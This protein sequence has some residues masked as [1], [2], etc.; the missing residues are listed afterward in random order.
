MKKKQLRNYFVSQLNSS[1][2][3]FCVKRDVFVLSK[4]SYLSMFIKY[5]QNYPHI[6]LHLPFSKVHNI[7]T[8]IKVENEKTQHF[9]NNISFDMCLSVNTENSWL[10]D[11]GFRIH[12]FSYTSQHN[13]CAYILYLLYHSKIGPFPYQKIYT[14]LDFLYASKM[15][16]NWL[17][18]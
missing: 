11:N 3:G 14:I 16:P 15:L 12:I 6:T 17:S 10:N 4:A 9:T 18:K 5:R 1:M 7:R 8:S 13:I 2:C